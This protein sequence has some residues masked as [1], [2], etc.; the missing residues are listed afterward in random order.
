MNRRFFAIAAASLLAAPIGRAEEAPGVGLRS[1]KGNQATVAPLAGTPTGVRITFHPAEWPNAKID[2]PEGRPWDWRST[3]TLLLDVK[4]PG[5][6]AVE[7]GV[8]VDDDPAADGVHHCR[9]ATGRLDAGESAV[10]SIALA[11][12]GPMALGMRGLPG[13][14]G[15]RSL[16]AGGDDE[17]NLGHVVAAQIFVH[18]PKGDRTLDIRSAR[19]AGAAAIAGIIDEFGQFTGDDWPGKVHSEAD[20]RA[21]HKADL[22]DVEAHPAPA[23]RDAYG[24]WKSGPKEKATGF[25]R[26]AK[27]DGKWWFVDP[28]GA[29]FF[30]LGV[31]CVTAGDHATI[32]TGRETM[33]TWLPKQGEPLARCYGRVFNVHS[34]PV[35]KG[36]TFSFY[37]AN[38]NRV[39]GPETFEPWADASLKRL[40]SWGFNTIGNWSDRRFA[41]MNRMPYVATLGIYGDFA[42]ISSGSDYWGRMRDPFD[43]R[44]VEAVRKS[45]EEGVKGIK[46]DP[47][48]LGYYVDNELSWGGGGDRGR[49]GLALGALDSPASSPAKRALLDRLQKQYGD[50]ARLNAAWKTSLADWKALE[51]PWKPSAEAGSWTTAFHDDLRGFVKEIART[52]FRTIRDELKKADPEHLYMGCRFAWKTPEA[53]AAAGETC[54]VVSFNIYERKVDPKEWAVLDAID[55][56]AIIGEFHFGALDRGMFHT[57]LVPTSS[58]EERAATYAGYVGSVLDHPSFIGCHWFQ[59]VDEPTTGRSYDGE[60]YN[61]GFLNVAD[62]AYP[63]LVAAARAIHAQAYPRRSGAK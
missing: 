26:T 7:F 36:E 56:P 1:L 27:R 10:F 53:I 32:V 44:F 18:A 61:I 38:L 15:E 62:L 11:K 51:A 33:F 9:S 16:S 21:R 47:W 14:R 22:A 63:E 4:N 54:D 57:G 55:K 46:G 58:Q 13:A 2:A 45:V 37:N 42:T 19:L 24:G 40:A 23:D 41:G 34:G 28:E 12:E 30:S 29:L 39:Y 59:F 60:N 25:F 52:Y 43:P 20:L 31:D 48:C 35:K 8:R 5:G 49:I 17:L 3:G 6:E 50:V